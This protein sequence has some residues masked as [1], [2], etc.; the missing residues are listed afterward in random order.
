MRMAEDCW[1]TADLVVF[2]DNGTLYVCDLKTGHGKVD[3]ADN[4][5][6]KLYALGALKSDYALMYDIDTIVVA[7]SQGRINHH[8]SVVYTV[9]EI[10]AFEEDLLAA[11]DAIATETDNYIPS[12]KGCQWCPVRAHCP[13]L[14]AQVHAAAQ[15]DFK[16]MTIDAL[17]DAMLEI[18]LMKSWIKGVEDQTKEHLEKGDPI[19][20]WKMVEGRRTRKWIDQVA[21]EKYFKN[22]VG[23]FQ[24]TCYNMKFMSP[25]QMEKAIAADGVKIRGTV[26]FDKV[27]EW[28]GGQ[29]TV[30]KE[31]D[32]R[33]ALVYGDKAASDFAT[34]DDDDLLD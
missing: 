34:C 9:E 27:V 12:D 33:E 25:A 21:A 5:Q 1:G 2:G 22:R 11:I 15:S 10:L 17:G 18:P 7:I 6:L 23:K 24:H 29:P 13:A 31:S 14:A 8:D 26:D 30:A 28:G 19:E 20:G 3:A 16:A 4:L 32:K